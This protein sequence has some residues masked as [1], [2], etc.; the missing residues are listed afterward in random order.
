MIKSIITGMILL[1]MFLFSQQRLDGV[2]AVIG[3]QIVLDSDIAQIVQY[4]KSQGNEVGDA[5]NFIDQLLMEKVITYQAKQDTILNKTITYDKVQENVDYRIK[6]LMDRLGTEEALLTTFN[7]QTMTELREEM[8]QLVEDQMY[9]DGK[10]KDIE[11]GVD[12]SPED[13]KV[14]YNKYQYDLPQVNEEIQLSHIIIN[15]ELTE[16]HKQKLIDQLN[17]IKKKIQSGTPFEDEARLYSQDPGS[18]N[19][20]GLYERVPRGKMVKEFDAVAFNLEEGQISEPFQT[21]FGFHIV[22]LEKRRGQLLDLRHILIKAEPDKQ[23]IKSAVHKL[24]SIRTLIKE[25][26]YTFKEAAL[27]FSDDKATRYN[28]G[29]LTNPATGDDRFDKLKLSTDEFYE[30][31][32]LKSGDLTKTYEDV[33]NS[34]KVARLILI[35]EIIP[36][37]KLSLEQDYDRIKRYALEEKKQE[38]LESYVKE[39]IPN[40]NIV[41][42]KKYKDCTYSF[43]WLQENKENL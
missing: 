41:I 42:S 11:E 29:I 19:N 35:N 31:A 30:V 10:K 32:G 9:T 36:A 37:H 16:I 34:R 23:E 28:A 20:G 15:P 39:K 4:Y 43:D 12:V 21:E 24:D 25:G 18:A 40:T 17:D 1:P 22:K 33:Y 26:K 3:D 2:A 14:F 8:Q 27:R 5:C 7:V 6:Y 13:L 38:K